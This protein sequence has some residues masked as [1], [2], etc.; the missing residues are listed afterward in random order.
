MQTFTVT[1]TE[2]SDETHD[3]RSF[4]TDRPE[5]F[6]FSPGQYCLFWL[7]SFSRPRPFTIASTPDEHYLNFTIKK[8]GE[9]TTA[10]FELKTG[11]SLKI[12]SPR[13][14][15]LSIRKPPTNP[16]VLIAGG[17][18]ITP[19]YPII[20]SFSSRSDITLL[21]SNR[22]DNDIIFKEQLNQLAQENDSFHLQFFVTHQDNTQF[23]A[24]RIDKKDLKKVQK[25]DTQWYV[26]GPPSMTKAIH[27]SLLEIGVSEEKIHKETWELPGKHEK[28]DE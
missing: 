24:K 2:I 7:D 18:G 23:T 28:D 9:F 27:D 20:S 22:T 1:I 11:D 16:I 17:S 3:T 13:D 10:M 14:S 5:G 19:F 6:D 26:C 12:T 25:K 8:I 4:T 15:K 21:Y